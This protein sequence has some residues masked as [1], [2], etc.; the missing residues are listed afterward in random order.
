[1]LWYAH[2]RLHRINAPELL[3]VQRDMILIG[4]GFAL[5]GTEPGTLRHVPWQDV[6]LE[7]PPA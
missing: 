4:T 2:W 1:M 6:A 3:K 7:R 5:P